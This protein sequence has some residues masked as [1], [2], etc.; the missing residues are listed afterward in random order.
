MRYSRKT[1]NYIKRIALFDLTHMIS[2][3]DLII[4][5]VETL[6]IYSGCYLEKEFTRLIHVNLLMVLYLP[7]N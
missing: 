4:F 1:L 7:I 3:V 5:N 6:I 2:T